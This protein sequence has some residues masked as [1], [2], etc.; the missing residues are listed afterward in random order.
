MRRLVARLLAVA[1][2]AAGLAG[3]LAAP[4]ATLEGQV[5]PDTVRVAEADLVLNGLGLRQ[6]TFLN[7]KGYAAGLYL[8]H[9]MRTTQEVLAYNGPKRVQMRMLLGASTNEFIKGFDGGIKKHVTPE[10]LAALK[11]RMDTFDGLLR[12]LNKVKPGDTVDLDYLP[13][14]G[15]VLRFNGAAQGQPIPGADL[16]DALLQIFI[17]DRPVDA[18]LKTGMLGG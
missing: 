13:G 16:Y 17:G 2:V 18:G 14:K 8:P 3:P 15:L 10:E 6:V 12:E 9:K 11:P 7:L 4:A 5:F 1:T